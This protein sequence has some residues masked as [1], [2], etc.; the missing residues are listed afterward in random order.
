MK[1]S[2]LAVSTLCL[3]GVSIACIVYLKNV[4]VGILLSFSDN[5]PPFLTN[6]TVW[7]IIFCEGIM[8]PLTCMPRLKGVS[9]ISSFSSVLPLL[10]LFIAIPHYFLNGDR[11]HG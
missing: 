4:I 5:V 8:L 6:S 3:V 2:I 1:V 7:A 10:L 9:Y 11:L